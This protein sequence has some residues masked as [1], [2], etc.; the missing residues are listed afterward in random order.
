M[1]YTYICTC[2]Y[3]CIP[4]CIPKVYMYYTYICIC[5]CLYICIPKVN[6]YTYVCMY[7][8]MYV[9]VYI[10]THTCTSSSSSSRA[11]SMDHPDPLSPPVS[12]VHFS[13][14]VF[15]V[16]SCID[17]ELLYIGSGWSSCLCTSM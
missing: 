16:I 14:E 10:C 9:C 7:V 15:K 11:A 1:F 5:T 13:R 3:I 8:C 17:T 6:M 2:L 12:I 4:I